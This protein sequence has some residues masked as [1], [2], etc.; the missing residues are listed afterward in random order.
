MLGAAQ[1]AAEEASATIRRLALVA[2]IE[3][4]ERPLRLDPIHLDALLDAL[5]PGVTTQATSA[6]GTVVSDIEPALPRI[7]ADRTHAQD[8]LAMLLAAAAKNTSATSAL[9]ISAARTSTGVA[10]SIGPLGS[11]SHTA[12]RLVASRLLSAMGATLTEQGDR[13]VVEFRHAALPGR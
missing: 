5:L 11:D 13:L 4:G 1:A 12:D 2:A 6:G 3:R 8:A 7:L 9:H 10:L